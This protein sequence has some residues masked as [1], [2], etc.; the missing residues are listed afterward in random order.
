M[1]S[2]KIILL[3]YLSSF[4]FGTE[5]LRSNW[6]KVETTGHDQNAFAVYLDESTFNYLSGKKDAYKVLNVIKIN[7]A[8]SKRIDSSTVVNRVELLSYDLD[9]KKQT[10]YIFG[11]KDDVNIMMPPIAEHFCLTCHVKANYK[12]L[13]LF[14]DRYMTSMLS[15]P[16]KIRLISNLYKTGFEVN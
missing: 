1:I 8:L 9:S 6:Y 13:P 3:L 11:P 4:S 16:K 2:I 15:S 10:F 14:L 7:D 12:G 5:W